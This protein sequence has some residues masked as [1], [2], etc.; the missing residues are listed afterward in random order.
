MI[1][2][3]I[4]DIKPI[5]NLNQELIIKYYNEFEDFLGYESKIIF[6]DYA[7]LGYTSS[8]YKRGKYFKYSSYGIPDNVIGQDID[9]VAV[10]IYKCI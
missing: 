3:N 4:N 6:N 8:R 1:K 2:F 9:N 5:D 7:L 10:I